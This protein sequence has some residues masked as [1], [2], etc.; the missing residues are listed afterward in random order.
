[1]TLDLIEFCADFVRW[2]HLV[3]DVPGLGALGRKK[4]VVVIEIFDC[5]ITLAWRFDRKEK[6]GGRL[7]SDSYHGHLDQRG[8][9]V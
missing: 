2:Y 6:G 3:I 7:L 4:L 5:F 9:V 1:M 8:K